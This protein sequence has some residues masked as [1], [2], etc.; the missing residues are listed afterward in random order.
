VKK[1]GTFSGNPFSDR[2]R[3]TCGGL[4]AEVHGGS[5]LTGVRAMLMVNGTRVGNEENVDVGE[6]R[7]I[8]GT[9]GGKAV[10]LR[11]TQGMFGTRYLLRV[12]GTE[13]RLGK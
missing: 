12:D 4:S 7:H 1:G 2:L 9:V 13:C 8:T 10:D 11:V 3:A 6:T 5:R